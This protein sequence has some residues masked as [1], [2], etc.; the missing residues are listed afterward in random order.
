M[1][2]AWLGLAI[3]FEVGWAVCMKVSAGL[4]RPWPTVGTLVMYLLSVACLSQATRALPLGT[5]YAVW[6]GAGAACIAVIGAVWFKEPLG[7]V[8]AAS[9]ALILLGIAGLHLGPSVR[10]GG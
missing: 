2:Y 7:A 3:V 8:R 1:A 5:S 9:I 4:T 10:A 6:T